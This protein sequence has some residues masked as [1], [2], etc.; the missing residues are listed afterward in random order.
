M[1]EKIIRRILQEAGTG[2]L[3]EILS[4]RLAPTDRQSLLLEVFRRCS[5]RVPPASLL[6]D[7]AGSRFVSPSLIGAKL[8]LMMDT[9]AF[10]LVPPGT[11]ILEFSPVAPL[12]NAAVLG[13]I[14]Q[15]RVVSTVRNTEVVADPTSVM[16]LECAVRRQRA[17]RGNPKDRSRIRL[18][19]SHRAL[20]GQT[21]D[22]PKFTAHFRLFSLC[23]AGRDE[24]AHGFER[25]ALREQVDFY[26]KLVE[27]A[28]GGWK[29]GFR[30][31][32]L[33]TDLAGTSRA[34]AEASLFP[35][36]AE[37]HPGVGTEFDEGRKSGIAYYRDL[38][39]R[40]KLADPEGN[41]A[42]FVMDGGFTD[43]TRRLLSNG[44]ER[45]LTSGIGTEYLIKIIGP[46]RFLKNLPGRISP[47]DSSR[48][49][50]ES[51][52]QRRHNSPGADVE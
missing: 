27:A 50:I 24:G 40:L 15:N 4:E 18:G 13:E 43:W 52:A 30:A 14:S 45:L 20:R 7:Y 39:F 23:T 51:S 5:E 9:L 19:S 12:G 22:N 6:A 49:G 29:T 11:D 46:E 31:D 44:K 37:H 21:F 36:L 1:S 47:L 33:L 25:D 26:L 17:L 2:D 28:A 16:A 10:S 35:F 32:I 34:W 3:I 41:V 38:C 8:F 42:D 48:P